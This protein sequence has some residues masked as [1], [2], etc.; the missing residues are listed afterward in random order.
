MELIY[1]MAPLLFFLFSMI[2]LFLMGG[3]NEVWMGERLPKH[4][5]KVGSILER[6]DVDG[7]DG[8]DFISE[9]QTELNRLRNKPRYEYRY[10]K[11]V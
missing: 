11:G 7:L 10:I 5:V 9:V 2:E 4:W 3:D 1:T 8:L 6:S